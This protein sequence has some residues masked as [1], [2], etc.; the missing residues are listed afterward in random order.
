MGGEK[1]DHGVTLTTRSTQ[2]QSHDTGTLCKKKPE[3]FPPCEKGAFITPR[4]LLENRGRFNMSK[5]NKVKIK[6]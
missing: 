6:G 3:G 1:H 2:P 5:N 4:L